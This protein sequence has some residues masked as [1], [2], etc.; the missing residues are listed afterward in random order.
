M[1]QQGTTVQYRVRQGAIPCFP[2]PPAKVYS[3]PAA[4]VTMTGKPCSS[5]TFFTGWPGLQKCS[6]LPK[7]NRLPYQTVT[8]IKKIMKKAYLYIRSAR[9]D[10]GE[11]TENGLQQQEEK[12]REHCRGH[13][14]KIAGVFSD[15]ASGTTF[16]RPGFKQM[17]ATIKPGRRWSTTLL[18]N[19]WDRLCRNPFEARRMA[20]YFEELGFAVKVLRENKSPLLQP[21]S[22]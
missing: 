4:Y 5:G 12:L 15:I 13:Q 3:I 1:A 11:V 20:A 10:E 22:N 7:V 6:A 14:L 16:E 9:V 19:S 2:L 8:K 18:V 17:L 21:L